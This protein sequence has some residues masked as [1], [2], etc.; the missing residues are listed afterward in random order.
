[1]PLPPSRGSVWPLLPISWNRS[2]RTIEGYH[3][4]STFRGMDAYGQ[5]V[6]MVSY[7][8]KINGWPFLFMDVY[9]CMY[10]CVSWM[11]WLYGKACWIREENI[12]DRCNWSLFVIL[13]IVDY[14]RRYV[15]SD[16]DI[17]FKWFDL[18]YFLEMIDREELIYLKVESGNSNQPR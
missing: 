3:R 12:M 18:G 10:M 11:L 5:T 13:P 6:R 1:M 7:A 14:Y 4:G 17:F 8:I 9:V 2:S 15:A 16:G